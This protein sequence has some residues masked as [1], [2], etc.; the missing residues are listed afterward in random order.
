MLKNTYRKEFIS[1]EL[2]IYERKGN[3]IQQLMEN[4]HTLIALKQNSQNIGY[5][6]KPIE[7]KGSFDRPNK[8]WEVQ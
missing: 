1:E 5:I 4:S 3:R 7:R 6:K 8:W 2:A